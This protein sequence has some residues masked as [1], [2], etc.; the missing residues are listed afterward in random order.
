MLQ[1]ARFRM[2][3]PPKPAAEPSAQQETPE[4]SS[5]A[6]LYPQKRSGRKS[7]GGR[8][9]SRRG[10]VEAAQALGLSHAADTT[11][12]A[13]IDEHVENRAVRKMLHTL[14]MRN[15]IEMNAIIDRTN[16]A[17]SRL[18]GL[19]MEDAIIALTT[20]GQRVA[21]IA[22][23]VGISPPYVTKTVQRVRARYDRLF[24]GDTVPERKHIAALAARREAI[25]R[26]EDPMSHTASFRDAS[27]LT[28][29]DG[30]PSE[31]APQEDSNEDGLLFTAEDGTQFEPD[32]DALIDAFGDDPSK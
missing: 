11:L 31:D 28:R 21:D 23:A 1:G 16:K 27:L 19:A 29:I 10:R 15:R 20:Q 3:H 18:A 6:S 12:H 32:W 5:E 17:E 7:K 25:A 24:R 8:K 2:C 26:G 30:S 9:G 13:L 22:A 14:V 4:C